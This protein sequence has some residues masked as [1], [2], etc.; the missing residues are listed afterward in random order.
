MSGQRDLYVMSTV[1]PY[2]VSVVRRGGAGTVRPYVPKPY[3]SPACHVGRHPW[4]DKERVEPGDVPGVRREVCA[5]ACH[6][7]A[8]H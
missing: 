1:R 2:L 6:D 7:G 5:C 3:L 4:C 8:G